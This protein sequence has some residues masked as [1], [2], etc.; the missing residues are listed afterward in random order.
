MP[1]DVVLLPSPLELLSEQLGTRARVAHLESRQFAW[2]AV[3]E[4]AVYADSRA[5]PYTI[6]CISCREF[7]GALR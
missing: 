3:N 6:I 5:D 2:E 4:L 7:L 1:G